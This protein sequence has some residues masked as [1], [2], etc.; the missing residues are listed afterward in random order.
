MLLLFPPKK[1]CIFC[2]CLFFLYLIIFFYIQVFFKNKTQKAL[3]IIILKLI[4]SQPTDCFAP[5]FFFL[6]GPSG[7]RSG[8]CISWSMVDSKYYCHICIA[9]DTVVQFKL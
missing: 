9:L 8:W 2:T 3:I 1:V 6:S 4:V 5:R 7:I